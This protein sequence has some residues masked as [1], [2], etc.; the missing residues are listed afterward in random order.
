MPKGCD[1]RLRCRLEVKHGRQSLR[2]ARVRVTTN[3][4]VRNLGNRVP[5]T[6]LGGDEEVRAVSIE[7]TYNVSVRWRGFCLEEILGLSRATPMHSRSLEQLVAE[8][9]LDFTEA[10]R[11]LLACAESGDQAECGPPPTGASHDP[12]DPAL[13]SMWGSRAEHTC[14]RDRLVRLLSPVQK[15]RSSER[16]DCCRCENNGS[17]RSQRPD[18]T[19]PIDFLLLFFHRRA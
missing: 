7:M 15:V 13:G 5:A 19:V 3:R 14:R 4:S 9:F 1:F 12:N 10:E 11:K 16:I 6:L 18:H 8:R 2:L 17:P